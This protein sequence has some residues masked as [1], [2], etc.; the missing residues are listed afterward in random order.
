VTTN[1]VA[2]VW[3]G[4]LGARDNIRLH[5][6]QIGDE[7]PKRKIW[8]YRREQIRRCPYRSREDN[9]FRPSDCLRDIRASKIDRATFAR[10]FRDAWAGVVPRHQARRSSQAKRHTQ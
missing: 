6:A 4:T 5:A 7:R 1:E 8:R 3:Q 9:E 2:W 10:T